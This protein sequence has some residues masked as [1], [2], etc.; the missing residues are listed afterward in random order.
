[1]KVPQSDMPETALWESFFDPDRLIQQLI[2]DAPFMGD[3]VELGAGYGTFTKSAL[4]SVTG[5]VH[6]Y[7]IEPHMC[8]NLEARFN[9]IIPLR[10]QVHCADVL[11]GGTGLTAGSISLVMAFNFLHFGDPQTLLDHVYHIL[12]PGGRLLIIHWRSDIDTPRGPDMHLRPTPETVCKW[13]HKSGFKLLQ[14]PDISGS[15]PWHYAV[16][17]TK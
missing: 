9:D 15:C 17:A 13:C 7:E 16:V 4:K 6:A 8:T 14:Q 5:K 2:P 11:I 12:G 3:A 1:M 10:L